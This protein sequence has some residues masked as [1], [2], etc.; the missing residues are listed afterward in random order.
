MGRGGVKGSRLF[1]IIIYPARFR[2][3]Y[4]DNEI[5]IHIL[6]LS[7]KNRYNKYLRI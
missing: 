2:R 1:L 5:F 3:C 4:L 6:K 7:E